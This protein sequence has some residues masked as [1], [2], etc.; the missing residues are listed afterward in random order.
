MRALWIAA[1]LAVVTVWAEA[2]QGAT[3]DDVPPGSVHRVAAIRIEGAGDLSASAIREVM[4]TRVPPWYQPWK[5][6]LDPTIFNPRVF[7][8]DL[9]R[10]ATALRES[11]HYQASIAHEIDVEGE[12]VSILL[13]IDEGPRVVVATVALEFEDFA[14]TE[15]EEAQLRNEVPLVPGA[16]FTQKQYDEGRDRLILALQRGAFAYAQVEKS[17][18]VNTETNEV[19][20]RYRLT[21]GR[22]AVFGSTDVAGTERVAERLV[23][24][25]IEFRTDDPYDPNKLDATQARIFGLRLF[26][27]VTV[28]PTNLAEQSGV[29]N[30]G[31]TVA[32]GPPRELLAGIGYG[33]EDGVRGQLRWQHNDFFGGGRQ[34]GFRLKGSQIEQAFEG[35]FRQ[36]YFLHPQQTF[37]APLTQLRDDEP[38]YTLQ[39]IRFAP[40][41]ERKLL[42][43]LRVALGYNIEYDDLSDVPGSTIARLEGGRDDY[44]ARGLL[45]SFTGVVERNTTADLLDPR[46]GSVV[47]LTVEQAGGPWQGA[48]SFYTAAVDAKKYWPLPGK[49]TFAARLRLGTGDGFGES[50]DL[51]IF[52]RFYAGGINSTRGYDRHMLGPLNAGDKPVG[53]RTLLEGS[54]ELRTPIYGNFGGV[55]FFDVGELR[56]KPASLTV[57]DLQFGAGVG[58]RYQTIVGP[59]RVDLGFPFEAPP[60]EPSWQVHFSIGQ[61]F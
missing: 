29:V 48:Y 10:I 45:S 22:S 21:R 57:G 43:R 6:W 50:R 20:V 9:D 13:T 61:A 11:G 5:R 53:G 36:P 42:P 49:R 27:S 18:V 40:R 51:P 33:L 17:A 26:R 19:A 16:V 8:A 7:R 60:G 47:N 58:V 15:A 46:E 44:V 4:Q 55:L 35:E 56:R 34:L 39:Q 28:R 31:V 38:G 52:R 30:V 1:A 14:A 3:V 54:V 32:E 24:R 12:R 41:V 23:R 37:I 25:E 59:L 2:T